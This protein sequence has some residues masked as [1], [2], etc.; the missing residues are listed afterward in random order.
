[1]KFLS[2]N[3]S[4]ESKFKKEFKAMSEEEKEAVRIRATNEEFQKST[5]DSIL[6]EF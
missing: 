3:L 4:T 5:G 6:R 1:M 2:E